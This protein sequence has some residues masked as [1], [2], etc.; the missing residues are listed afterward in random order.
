MGTDVVLDEDICMWLSITFLF[1]RGGRFYFCF[2]M[3]KVKF[4]DFKLTHPSLQL[5]LK[6]NTFIANIGS[7]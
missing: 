1:L 4:R 6:L 3:N 5:R 7:G 2:Q